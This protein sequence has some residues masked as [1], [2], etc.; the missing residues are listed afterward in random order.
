MKTMKHKHEGASKRCIH[1]PCIDP[2]A[3]LFVIDTN[4]DNDDNDS[5]AKIINFTYTNLWPLIYVANTQHQNLSITLNY[6]QIIRQLHKICSPF[7][8][9]FCESSIECFKPQGFFKANFDKP[10]ELL[11]NST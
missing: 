1:H 6:S 10:L 9:L 11:F 4:E 7:D 2:K 3:I 8:K 5:K